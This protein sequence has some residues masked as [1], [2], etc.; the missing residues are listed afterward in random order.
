M[1]LSTPL[2]H[3][4]G[5]GLCSLLMFAVM[6]GAFSM[7]MI[8]FHNG[9][10][11]DYSFSQAHVFAAEVG[12]AVFQAMFWPANKLDWHSRSLMFVLPLLYGAI[13]YGLFLA[14]RRCLRSFRRVKASG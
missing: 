7:A 10:S 8:T 11:S 9:P 14:V 2:Q 5:W 12:A 4:L 13:L 1:K 3:L 6:V